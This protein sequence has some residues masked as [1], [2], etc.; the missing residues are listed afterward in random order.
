MNRY[1]IMIS[2]IS[3]LCLGIIVSF[4]TNPFQSTCDYTDKELLE[5]N[6][7]QIKNLA[8]Q[9]NNLAEGK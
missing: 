1:L 2:V 6:R 3:V 8:E 7:Q 9:L 5:K 4:G